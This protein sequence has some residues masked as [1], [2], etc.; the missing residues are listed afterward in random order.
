MLDSLDC[1]CITHR[2]DTSHLCDF[3]N[4][5][6]VVINPR[7]H[8]PPS[9]LSLRSPLCQSPQRMHTR[10]GTRREGGLRQSV[11]ETLCRDCAVAS[12]DPHKLSNHLLKSLPGCCRETCRLQ[13]RRYLF[14]FSSSGATAPDSCC[15]PYSSK[16]SGQMR[17]VETASGRRSVARTPVK[18]YQRGLGMNSLTS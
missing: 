16:R 18:R 14:C 8:S 7:C 11:R 3:G 9:R 5:I 10:T 12:R 2:V 17:R 6:K 4:Q 1:P 13:P 15:T